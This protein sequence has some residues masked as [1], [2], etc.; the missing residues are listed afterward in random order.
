M[1][2]MWN[3]AATER[4][5]WRQAMKIKTLQVMEVVNAGQNIYTIKHH[6]ISG[7]MWTIA[8]TERQKW[9]KAMNTK[10]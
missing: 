6:V 9:R 8:A 7:G 2:S 4:Q 5:K 3:R 1:G 10:T